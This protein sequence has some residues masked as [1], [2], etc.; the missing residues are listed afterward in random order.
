MSATFKPVANIQE[1]LRLNF[2]KEGHTMNPNET[3]SKEQ[4]DLSPYCLQYR[5]LKKISRQVKQTATLL[6]GG[7][8]LYC[9]LNVYNCVLSIVYICELDAAFAWRYFHDNS[10]RDVVQNMEMTSDQAVIDEVE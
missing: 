4:S 8:R 5:L 2:I 3:A 9:C 7:K 1:F 6:T 10:A